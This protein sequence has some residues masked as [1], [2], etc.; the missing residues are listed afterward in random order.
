MP[1]V[2]SCLKVPNYP[3]WKRRYDSPEAT[4]LRH[5]L[6]LTKQQILRNPDDP[7][8]VVLLIEVEDLRQAH[9]ALQSDELRTFV[10]RG[11]I[12]QRTVYYQNAEARPRPAGDYLP[13]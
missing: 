3:A 11:P 5:K 4:A 8:D 9:H 1:F 6:G 10:A 13:Y 2:V 7:N 12:L